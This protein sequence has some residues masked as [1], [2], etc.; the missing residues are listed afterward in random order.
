M[1]ITVLLLCAAALPLIGVF[2]HC[3]L[4]SAAST[5]RLEVTR[6][7]RVLTKQLAVVD[8]KGAVTRSLSSS[9]TAA[10]AGSNCARWQWMFAFCR[11]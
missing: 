10:A 6:R 3:S 8:A 2:F 1:V 5:S 4:Y 9:Y 7:A 11:T